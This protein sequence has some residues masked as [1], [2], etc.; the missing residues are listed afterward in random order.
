MIIFSDL[1]NCMLDSRYTARELRVFVRSLI[2]KGIL[3]S[4]ISSKTE[5]EILYHLDEL[6]IEASFG[7]ENGCLVSVRKK[8]YEFGTGSSIIKGD[9]LKISK[10]ISVDIELLSEMEGERIKN[11]TKL[12]EHLIPLARMRRFS[13]PFIV[14]RGKIKEFTKELCSLGYAVWLGGGFYQISKGCSKGR[15]VRIIRQHIGGYAIGIG[16][17]ENDYDMLDECD[18]PVILN[19]DG[20]SKYRSFKG[21]GPEVWKWTVEKLLEEING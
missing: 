13:E 3:L 18:Y 7:A 11:Y 1:D 10:K 17:S 5:K 20:S 15:A 6:G 2:N 19:N 4:I 21:H 8:R 12:P 14:S 9:L 16:D